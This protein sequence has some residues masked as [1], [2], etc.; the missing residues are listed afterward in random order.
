MLGSHFLVLMVSTL[1]SLKLLL[2]KYITTAPIT[3]SQQYFQ[4][5]FNGTDAGIICVLNVTR[6]FVL[7]SPFIMYP[8]GSGH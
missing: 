2:G 8:I 1:Q 7:P 6:Q 4:N 5:Q 3:Q